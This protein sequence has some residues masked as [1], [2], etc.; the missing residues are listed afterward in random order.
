MKSNIVRKD[1]LRVVF[2]ISIVVVCNGRDET[3]S[4]FETAV[5]ESGV[6]QGNLY[7]FDF[8]GYFI[9]IGIPSDYDKAN[10]DFKTLF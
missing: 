4:Q 8:G 10:E 9:D 3:S 2:I 7:A 1:L 6:K 5:L